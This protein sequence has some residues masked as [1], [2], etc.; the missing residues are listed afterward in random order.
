[1]PLRNH[2]RALFRASRL[3]LRQLAEKSGVRR[4]SIARFLEG[5]NLH[6]ANLEKLLRALGYRL[7]LSRE[8][9][10]LPSR[11]RV[12]RN[13]LAR[14]CKARGIS[15]LAL[16]GSVLTGNFHKGSD[17]DVLADFEKPITYFDLVDL[18][19]ELQTLLKTPHPVHIVTIQ[20]LS[21]LLLEEV[22][23]RSKTVYEKAA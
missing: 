11:V 12:D 14:F 15:Y 4:Q 10:C 5:G 21:P 8:T 19:K 16:Y 23:I 9:S 22:M 2:I 17:I 18:E 6:I 3:S 20:G 1:M 13:R 7:L